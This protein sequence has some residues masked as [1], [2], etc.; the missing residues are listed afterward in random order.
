MEAKTKKRRARKSKETKYAPIP[1]L[2]D[3]RPPKELGD[4]MAGLFKNMVYDP[5]RGVLIRTA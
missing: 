3:P 4:M 2:S 5:E 1:K